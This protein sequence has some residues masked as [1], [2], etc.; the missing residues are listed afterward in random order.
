[1]INKY[2]HKNVLIV[3][4][5]KSGLACI[6]FLAKKQAFCYVYD[7]NKQK[8]KTVASFPDI[9][10][11]NKIDDDIIKIIDYMVISPGVSVFSEY[12]KLAKLYGVRVVSELELGC[13]FARGKVIGVTGTN[14]KTTTSSLLYNVLKTAQKPAVLCGN[15]GSPIT[16]NILPFKTNYVVEMSSFQLESYQKL[17]T[18]MA[19]ITNISPNHL[20]RHLNFKN[21]KNAKLNIIKSLK[22]TG[23]LILNYDDK[24][25]KNLDLK[26]IHCKIAWVSTQKEIEGYYLKDKVVYFKNKNKVIK[27]VDLSQIKLVGKH[28]LQNALFVVACM[29]K[30]KIDLTIIEKGITKFEPICHRIQF[31]KSVNGVAYV[32]DSKST[33][34]DSTITAIK[35]FSK[36]PLILIV[37]GSDKGV[38]YDRLAKKVSKCKNIKLVVVQ[39]AT[40]KKIVASLKANKVKNYVVAES[41][42]N[43]LETATKHAQRG[44]TIL[45]SPA[46]ASFDF[47]ESYEQRGEKFIKYVE[48]LKDE[49]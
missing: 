34:E 46:C 16:E 45:L 13:S 10:I 4:L 28:N 24:H 18:D 19:I 32:N 47:F 9:T 36:T 8:L 40:Q 12:V 38:M 2:K 27:L 26:N 43:A 1:M 11:L 3:G 23:L 41:F 5:G 39:G 30:L 49:N 35:S 48:R 6:N 17:K 14:G 31:V 29:H 7:D 22:R 42:E 37:G 21:Y 15:I 25:L 33:S 20:D 44:D